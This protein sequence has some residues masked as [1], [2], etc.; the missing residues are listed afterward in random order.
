M[1]DLEKRLTDK[2]ENTHDKVLEVQKNFTWKFKD[3]ED[4][5]NTRVTKAYVD[6]CMRLVEEKLS[7]KLLSEF[8]MDKNKYEELSTELKKRIRNLEN[9]TNDRIKQNKDSIKELKEQMEK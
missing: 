5:L 6:D 3:L 9:T 7:N 2:I 8:E 1:S 4:L